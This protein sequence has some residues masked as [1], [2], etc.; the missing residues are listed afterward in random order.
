MI[1]AYSKQLEFLSE[2]MI[3]GLS[4]DPLFERSE[5]RSILDMKSIL[6]LE[7]L[8]ETIELMEHTILFFKLYLHLSEFN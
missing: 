1:L 3:S 5:L 8:C 6:S 2:R 7:I 4:I